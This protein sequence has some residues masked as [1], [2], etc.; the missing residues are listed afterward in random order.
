VFKWIKKPTSVIML[1]MIVIGSFL[2]V[3]D[4]V[5]VKANSSTIFVDDDN[6]SGPWDGSPQH[7]YQN[8]TSALQHAAVNDIIFVNSGTY[9]ENIHVNKSISLIGEN[10]HDT[11]IDSNFTATN[12]VFITANN[13]NI[14]NFT[15]RNVDYT[16][17]K[18]AVHVEFSNGCNINNNIITN[19]IVTWVLEGIQLLNS[20]DCTVANNQILP[21]NGDEERGA[22]GVKLVYSSGN[23]VIN[24]TISSVTSGISFTRSEG[25]KIEANELYS[26]WYGIR[27]SDSS[28]NTV[29]ANNISNNWHGIYIVSYDLPAINNLIYHNN[30]V[31]NTYQA[32]AYNH[33]NIWHSGYPSGGNYW[34]D[35][36]GTDLYSGPFQNISGSDGIGDTPYIIDENNTDRYPLIS[37]Y[38]CWNIA[39][40]NYDFKVDIF[41]VVLA[42]VAY[43]ATPSDPHWD[44]RADIANPYEV[45]NIFDI[46]TIVGSYGEEYQ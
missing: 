31:N 33:T 46:V 22:I 23:T 1:F 37:P 24:N 3:F 42:A 4:I 5:T 29:V 38:T 14:V 30:F 9:Y 8:I 10:K 35:Y 44:A 16:W 13:V 7:P 45:I 19:T 17:G 28:D 12:V 43:G 2:S 41:D 34:N 32:T 6:V 15:I 39:D 18:Y 21:F 25:N 20:S 11:I 36:N 40:I 26:N 27:L